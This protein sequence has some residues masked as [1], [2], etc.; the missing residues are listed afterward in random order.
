MKLLGGSLG[1]QIILTSVFFLIA[2]TLEALADIIVFVFIGFRVRRF[3]ANLVLELANS[4]TSTTPP[5]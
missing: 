4:T 5:N 1:G 2:I 3:L